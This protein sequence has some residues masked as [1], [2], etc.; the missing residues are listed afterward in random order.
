MNG[1]R[2]PK[3]TTR[4]MATG[5]RVALYYPQG[6]AALGRPILYDVE[7]N[8]DAFEKVHEAVCT[9]VRVYAFC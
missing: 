7:L 1:V 6:A 3:G 9:C 8:A 5:S 4:P 2:V